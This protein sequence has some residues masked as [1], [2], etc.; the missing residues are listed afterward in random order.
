MYSLAGPLPRALQRHAPLVSATAA[1]VQPRQPLPPPCSS[2][3]GLLASLPLLLAS[4]AC[5]APAVEAKRTGLSA[6]QVSA[7]LARDL[8]VGKYFINAEGLTTDIWRED[9]LFVDP[10]NTTKGLRKYMAALDLLFDPSVSTLVLDTIAVTGPRTVY[11]TWTLGGMLRLP[12][13][14]VVAPFKGT[15]TYTLD[16][17]GLIERQGA[18]G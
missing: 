5:A 2:R 10:T 18:L 13:R 1:V 11:A 15:S 6:D 9:A 12:W 14:P 4:T 8:A 17:D 7:L 3:R 16:S